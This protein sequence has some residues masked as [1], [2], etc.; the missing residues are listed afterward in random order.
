M[1]KPKKKGN[2]D[3]SL[4]TVELRRAIFL[5]F[6]NGQALLQEAEL[7]HEHGHHARAG[8]LAAVG[9]TEVAKTRFCIG[10]LDGA[11]DYKSLSDHVAFWDLWQHHAKKGD[12]A[13]MSGPE[14]SPLRQVIERQLGPQPGTNLERFRVGCLY[15]DVRELSPPPERVGSIQAMPLIFWDPTERIR[16]HEAESLLRVLR[17]FVKD[18]APMVETVRAVG[19]KEGRAWAEEFK[20]AWDKRFPDNPIRLV[21]TPSMNL[22]PV[23]RTLTHH[24]TDIYVIEWLDMGLEPMTGSSLFAEVLAPAATDYPEITPHLIGVREPEGLLAALEA[25]EREVRRRR[26]YPLVHIETHGNTLSLGRRLGKRITFGELGPAL[27]GINEACC[28]HLVVTLAACWGEHSIQIMDP[29]DR[30]PVLAFLVI[31]E[32]IEPEVV[33]DCYRRYFHTIVRTRDG[34]EAIRR[35]NEPLAARKNQ[36]HFIPAERMFRGV[37]N[38]YVRGYCNPEFVLEERIAAMDPKLARG[39]IVDPAAPIARAEW[40][41]SRMLDDLPAQFEKVR[42]RFFM[43]DL[44][45]RNRERFPVRYEEMDRPPGIL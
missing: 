21:E 23:H 44:D 29:Q 20:H 8:A 35:M 14:S 2:P 26:V 34:Q 42:D 16:V 11:D 30:A 1:G 33:T 31:D 43:F 24:L 19:L 28:L 10:L 7:L 32:E 15:A 25:I 27:I 22:A 4:K 45:E 17:Q 41:V 3:R 36:F 13:F 40:M 38:S 9:M 5:S 39:P 18:V 12:H 37:W 6:R